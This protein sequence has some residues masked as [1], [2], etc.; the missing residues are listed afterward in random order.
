MKWIRVKSNGEF[1]VILIGKGDL[2]FNAGQGQL[3]SCQR[4]WFDIVPYKIF[5][6]TESQSM[7]LLPCTTKKNIKAESD[8]IICSHYALYT[9]FLPKTQS[10]NNRISHVYH[11]PCL[12]FSPQSLYTDSPSCKT[13]S[14][15]CVLF[16]SLQ[17]AI[18]TLSD[19]ASGFDFFPSH[20]HPQNSVKFI[21]FLFLSCFSESRV[22]THKNGEIS[23]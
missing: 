4:N 9:S 15:M 16:E 3:K 2:F 12:T 21:K 17:V 5:K 22:F 18:F 6:W 11:K 8:W 7:L 14:R 19:L 13:L 20:W 23:R 1:H 10:K